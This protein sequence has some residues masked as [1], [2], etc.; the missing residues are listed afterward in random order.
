MG[1]QNTDSFAAYAEAFQI[2]AKYDQGG[3]VL[4]CEHDV[5]YAGSSDDAGGFADRVSWED[6]ARLAA[7]GWHVNGEYNCMF[8][9]V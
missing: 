9:F 7:L 6:L 8:R 3:D 5:L 1:E 2:M 4:H